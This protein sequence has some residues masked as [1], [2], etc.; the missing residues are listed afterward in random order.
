MNRAGARSTCGPGLLQP[1]H[2]FLDFGGT[3]LSEASF[4]RDDAKATLLEDA[5]GR[6]VVVS[7][8]RVERA[9]LINSQERVEGAGR[10]PL[11]PVGA[12]D[13]VRDLALVGVTPRPD[14]SGDF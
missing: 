8:A 4:R 5:V 6:E 11:A 12:A 2:K 1:Q 10:D 14:R 9:R 7:D 13:P 3:R